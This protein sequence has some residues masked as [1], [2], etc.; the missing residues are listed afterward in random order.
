MAAATTVD[1]YRNFVKPIAEF[2]NIMP[3]ARAAMAHGVTGA[4]LYW[5]YDELFG[6]QAPIGSK[7][8]Q[9]DTFDKIMMNLWRSEFFGLVGEIISP[10]EKGIA[11][12]VSQPVIIRNGQEAF[13]Q[14]TQAYL[15][16]KTPSQAAEDWVKKSVVGFAQAKTLYQTSKSKYYKDFQSLR[17][18]TQKF[19][20][21]H[22]MS[23]YS[24]EGTINRRTPYYRNLKDAMMFGSD[25]DVA[26]QYWKAF[27]FIVTDLESSPGGTSVGYRIKQ[28]R[29][30]L[31]QV[32]K[33][34]EP[35][36]ISDN[37]KG[38]SSNDKKAFLEWLTPE[39]KEL[40]K[41]MENQFQYKLRNYL[42]IIGNRKYRDAYF[43]YPNHA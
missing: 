37:P 30:Q 41:S 24:S 20:T 4:A 2:G 43:V 18:M 42:R 10:Y 27:N 40:A 21:E 22:D 23:M 6:K 13:K 32:I 36:N 15:G 28:A 5:M 31:K 7:M 3:I 14:F 16:G 1:S 34:Y 26:K 17:A 9:D 39:N 35:L 19:K 29:K 25:E 12:P 11:A 8:K 33:H 38:T